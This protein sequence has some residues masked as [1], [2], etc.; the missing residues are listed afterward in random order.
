MRFHRLTP[1]EKKDG[2]ASN[3]K[4]SLK[5]LLSLEPKA[6]DLY[7]YIGRFRIHLAERLVL[8]IFFKN[9]TLDDLYCCVLYKEKYRNEAWRIL[10]SRLQQ[11]A[12]S[13]VILLDIAHKIPD[14]TEPAIKEVLGLNVCLTLEDLSQLLAL[15]HIKD[16]GIEKK[17]RE[18]KE[19]ET[20]RTSRVD[21]ILD[22]LVKLDEQ[23]K[24]LS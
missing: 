5:T 18:L 9:A 24:E 15:R 12:H 8:K 3:M 23:L 11:D 16:S 2:I 19:K 10:V 4:K 6:S 21:A 1:E 22:H 7:Q 20:K 14:L 17:L 13:K